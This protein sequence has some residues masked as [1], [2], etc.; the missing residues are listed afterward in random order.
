MN[1]AYLVDA[2]RSPTGRHDGSL[3]Q[4]HPM[5]LGAEVLRALVERNPIPAE[6]YDDVILGLI[7]AIGPN[8]GNLARF[9]WLG[10]GVR[11]S[12]A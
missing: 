12:R 10:A 6:D 5:D 7:D 3:G 9:C 2:L 8:A 11:N 4:W 1:E